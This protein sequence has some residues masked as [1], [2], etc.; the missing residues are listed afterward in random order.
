MDKRKTT[1][2]MNEIQIKHG[3]MVITYMIQQVPQFHYLQKLSIYV[4]DE[5]EDAAKR[6]LD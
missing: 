3:A 2:V 4:I 6:H 5:I 1:L